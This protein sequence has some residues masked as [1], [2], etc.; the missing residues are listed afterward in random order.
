MKKKILLTAAAVVVLLVSAVTAGSF[1]LVNYA[2]VDAPRHRDS[3]FNRAIAN[4]PE[5]RS[6]IDSLQ[7]EGALRDT[8]VVMPTGE[9]A[10]AIFARS[11]KA[12]GATA[13][14]VHGYT[15][16]A[17]SM[18]MIARIYNHFLNYNILLPDLH[19]HGQSYG[20]DIQ[21]GWKDV[22]T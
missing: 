14:L 13:V 6:W 22:S 10:H 3:S 2:L 1:Y 9:R 15:D 16:N 7:A 12:H 21:M 18:L 8:F 20:K 4:Y 11:S 5:L 19:A 17:T